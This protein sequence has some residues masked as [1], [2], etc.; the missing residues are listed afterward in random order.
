[1][2]GVFLSL[3]RMLPECYPIATP[4]EHLLDNEHGLGRLLDY[5]VI[6]PRLSSL[7]AWSATELGQPELNDLTVDG[8]PAY[9]WPHEDHAVWEPRAGRI[10]GQVVRAATRAPTAVK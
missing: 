8:T 7:Y 10:A 5:A 9:A 2:V 6:H 4:L 3:G 1:M